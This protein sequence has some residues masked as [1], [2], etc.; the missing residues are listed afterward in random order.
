[1]T[2]TIPGTTLPTL[3]GLEARPGGGG[4]TSTVVSR[5]KTVGGGELDGGFDSSVLDTSAARNEEARRRTQFAPS[6]TR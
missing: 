6:Q 5:I 4:F 3:E 2:G 1:M